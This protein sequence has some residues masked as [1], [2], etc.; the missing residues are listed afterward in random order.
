MKKPQ[1]TKRH[2]AQ[3]LPLLSSQNVL[4]QSQFEAQRGN[5]TEAI[6]LLKIALKNKLT[7]IEEVRINPFFI[8]SLPEFPIFV[9]KILLSMNKR[10][11][12]KQD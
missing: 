9:Q 2:I 7:T 12:C 10:A 4:L 6:Q 8:P 11:K 1:S 5:T 3:A